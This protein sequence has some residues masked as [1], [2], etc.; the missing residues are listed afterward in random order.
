M[1]VE[2]GYDAEYFMTR[3]PIFEAMEYLASLEYRGRDNWEQA[4]MIAY[5][6][7][8]VNSK[9]VLKPSEI[10]KYIWDEN[11]EPETVSA[12]D[13]ERLKQKADYLEKKL[14]GGLSNENTP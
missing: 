2:G 8:Q 6:V 9:K 14:Y 1:V 10:I 5:M 4:R 12:V 3:M 7:A 13:L 11:K